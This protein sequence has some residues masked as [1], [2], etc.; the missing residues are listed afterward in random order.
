M[1]VGYGHFARS[2]KK[3]IKEVTI[4]EKEDQWT[5]V[6]KG[7]SNQGARKKGKEVKSI[8][9]APAAKGPSA[10]HVV[11][12]PKAAPNPFFVL[13][14]SENILEEG[15]MEQLDT[16]DIGTNE[17]IP[18]KDQADSSFL[19]P[20]VSP[21]PKEISP[22]YADI[23]WKKHGVSS[24]S[25]EDESLSNPKEAGSL[26]RKFRKKRQKGSRP[27]VVRPL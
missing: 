22:S 10:S 19:S 27:K 21:L 20:G 15:E 18:L 25:L 8:S 2:C 13:S 11:V 17:S 12:S 26:R 23:A 24:G 7:N 9:G 1:S 16:L 3:R 14:S 4:I 6:Q 5:Q